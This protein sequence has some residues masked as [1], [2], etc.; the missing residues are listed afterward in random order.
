MGP[1]T[2]S[3]KNVSVLY[4]SASNRIFCIELL[5]VKKIIQIPELEGLPGATDDV[6]GVFNYS[7]KI[8]PVFDLAVLMGV[9]RKES[10]TLNTMLLLLSNNKNEVGLVIDEVKSQGNIEEEYLHA[11]EFIQGKNTFLRSIIS[12]NNASV[13]IPELNKII[14][15][16]LSLVN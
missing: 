9:E 11:T 16:E 14:S 12:Q 15:R 5:Y 4:V 1:D 3:N 2:T 10:Y 7:G 6:V 8:I 13:M